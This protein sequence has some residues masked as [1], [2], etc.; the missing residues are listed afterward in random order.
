MAMVVIPS[1]LSLVLLLLLPVAVARHGGRTLVF[2]LASQSNMSGR[3]D[4]TNVSWDGVVPPECAPSPWI[5]HLSPDLHW[6]RA[7]EPLHAGIDDGNVLG[8]G[9][10]M[11]FAHAVL[12]SKGSVPPGAVVRLV[13]YA[14]GAS[15]IAN[16]S[17]G[18]ERSCM[19]GW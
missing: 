7:C 19:S 11:P 5:L 9:P 6:E 8:I 14:Q 15:P 3:G 10:C 12:S 16:W 4:A 18:T 1:I 2:I 17:R 13:P